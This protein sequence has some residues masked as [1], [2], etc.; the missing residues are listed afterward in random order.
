ML[1]DCWRVIER[2]DESLLQHRLRPLV[3]LEACLGHFG[4]SPR[5]FPDAVTS[6]VV[7]LSAAKPSFKELTDEI[8]LSL[9]LH[10]RDRSES[11]RVEEWAKRLLRFSELRRRS[12]R[13]RAQAKC[14]SRAAAKLHVLHL[15]AFL[16]DYGL[17][18][19]DLR[20]L[21]TVLKIADATVKRRT[22]QKRLARRD[23]DLASALFEFRLV[24]VTEYAI[25]RLRREGTT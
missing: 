18:S 19:Q 14:G 12:L 5:P 11:V 16:M 2:T 25:E 9:R 20:F 17:V 3:G 4:L 23:P 1:A 22:L 6:E 13:S 15:A 21:N 7:D 24:L 8:L 10:L